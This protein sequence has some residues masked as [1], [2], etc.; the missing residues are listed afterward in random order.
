MTMRDVAAAAGVST[1][2]VSRVIN[3][4]ARVDDARAQRVR[5]AIEDLNYR[6][7]LIARGLR[8]QTTSV[9]ALVVAD[10]ASPFFTAVCRGVED[11]ARRY[12]Y[13]VILCDADDDIEKETEYVNVLASQA[14]A[15]VII[16]PESER[17][18]VG[19]LVRNGIAI[20]A[21]DRKLTLKTDSVHSNSRAGA[22]DATRHLLE[23]GARRIGCITGPRLVSTAED[24]LDGYRA[25][26]A[27]ASLRGDPELV[28]YA[29]YREDGGYRA[30]KRM[31]ELP[32]PPDALF[33][34]NNSMLVGAFGAC[35]EAG[36]Q[37]PDELSIVGFDDLEWANYTQ[38]SITTVRQATYEIGSA[39]AQL[40]IDRIKNPDA[41]V[42]EMV[43]EVE[44]MI[45]GS[46]VKSNAA[47]AL[48]DLPRPNARMVL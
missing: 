31:L 1:A 36:V 30:A 43:F 21:L 24:R 23:S 27:G 9:I 16:S 22:Y 32:E 48:P 47:R 40:L 20:V 37:I 44:L 25:A 39:A 4:T 19:P 46:S 10:I 3:Q 26:L 29:N 5:K 13:S 17:T 2:T 34:A 14:V 42:E 38:P 28:E 6:P 33:V 45:R 7:N 18:D 41:P 12:G 35:L 11:T 8:V 15:G